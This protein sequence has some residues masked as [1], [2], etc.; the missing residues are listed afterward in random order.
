MEMEKIRESTYRV[1]GK[2]AFR[3]VAFSG[4]HSKWR[5]IARSKEMGINVRSAGKE[6]AQ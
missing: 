5:K 2:D 1:C 3:L 4:D 6:V